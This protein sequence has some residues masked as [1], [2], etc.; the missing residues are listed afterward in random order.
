MPLGWGREAGRTELSLHFCDTNLCVRV[1][2]KCALSP[3]KQVP[4]H[5]SPMYK[6]VTKHSRPRSQRA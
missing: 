6:F 2:T 5:S 1:E 3:P 4:G